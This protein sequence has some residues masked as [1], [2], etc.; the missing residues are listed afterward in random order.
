MPRSTREWALRKIEMAEGNLETAIAH[1][2]EVRE[3]YAKPQPLIADH[4][5][6]M[7]FASLEVRNTLERLRGSF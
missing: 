6:Q 7:Q 1:L 3:R 4:L 2:E 5:Q